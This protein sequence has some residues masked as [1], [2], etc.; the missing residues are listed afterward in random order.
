MPGRC[1]SA[2]ACAARCRPGRRC[3]CRPSSR[4]RSASLRARSS[5]PRTKPAATNRAAPPVGRH[6]PQ[7][8]RPLVDDRAH[9]RDPPARRPGRLACARRGQ[10]AEVRAVARDGAD[11][12][13]RSAVLDPPEAAEREPAATRRPGRIAR[14]RRPGRAP[15]AGSSRR[16]RRARGRAARSSRP[17]GEG[18]G[19]AQEQRGRRR[20]GPGAET[21]A[22][23]LARIEK[24]DAVA[25]GPR[26]REAYRLASRARLRAG[27]VPLALQQAP[28]GRRPLRQ[29]VGGSQA[30]IEHAPAP[31]Q[32]AHRRRARGRFQL[33]ELRE[34]LID[35]A[36]LE[37]KPKLGQPA[38]PAGWCSPSASAPFLAPLSCPR[39][40]PVH[41]RSGRIFAHRGADLRVAAHQVAG[42]RPLRG[43]RRCRSPRPPRAA[44]SPSPAAILTVARR[45]AVDHLPVEA[46]GLGRHRWRDLVRRARCPSSRSAS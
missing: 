17:S 8:R 1:R 43:Q 11:V 31:A 20:G 5:A 37:L 38:R 23:P 45:T 29:R 39:D 19:A 34:R 7:A 42:A 21:H 32:R 40:Q 18:T 41:Q 9:E 36:W 13:L 22:W 16:G 10:A 44:R 6:R 28:P 46:L 25:A 30:A 15:C 14:R 2:P 3:R 27:R 4:R 33:A 35:D 24:I 26:S 12:A